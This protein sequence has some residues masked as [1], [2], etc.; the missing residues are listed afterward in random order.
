MKEELNYFQDLLQPWKLVSLLLGIM[1]LI[2]G[3]GF[4]NVPDWD[5]GVSFAMAIPTYLTAGWVMRKVSDHEYYLFV[6][7]GFYMMLSVD[8]SYYVYWAFVN[9]TVIGTFRFA[10]DG[11]SSAMYLTYGLI[12]YPQGSLKQVSSS[13]FKSF[14]N[15]D[16]PL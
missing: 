4:F 14:R 9:P 5:I 7:C 2:W 13:L 15:T 3:A 11:V 10:N 8:T 16:V 12:L 6:L 1:F